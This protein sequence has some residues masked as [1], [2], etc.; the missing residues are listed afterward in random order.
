ML[1]FGLRQP[2]CKRVVDQAFHLSRSI[3]EYLLFLTAQLTFLFAKLALLLAQRSLL[4][5]KLSLSLACLGLQ[6]AKF[7]LQVADFFLNAPKVFFRAALPKSFQL[8]FQFVQV[9]SHIGNFNANSFLLF[10]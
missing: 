4:L 1:L 3:P 8:R 5:S 9:F 10:S 2:M 6:V 7:A